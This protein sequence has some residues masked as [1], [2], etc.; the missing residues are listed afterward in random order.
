MHRRRHARTPHAFLSAHNL[1]E[2]HREEF[3]EARCPTH[4]RCHSPGA[5]HSLL[6]P[7][8]VERSIDGVAHCPLRKGNCYSPSITSASVNI[9]PKIKAVAG[10]CHRLSNDIQEA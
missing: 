4:V 10:I 7:C 2:E 1:H 8:S 3:C 6:P 9:G 5:L